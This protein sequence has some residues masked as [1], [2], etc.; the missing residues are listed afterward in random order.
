MHGKYF[1]L[2]HWVRIHLRIFEC[3]TYLNIIFYITAL[4]ILGVFGDCDPKYTIMYSP[5]RPCAYFQCQP[6]DKY[7]CTCLQ[8]STDPSVSCNHLCCRYSRICDDINW[9]CVHINKYIEVP[10]QYCNSFQN[11]FPIS[12]ISE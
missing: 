6:A 4:N 9:N 12:S 5:P 10:K 3:F 8:L 2:S 1:Y 11:P 7:R